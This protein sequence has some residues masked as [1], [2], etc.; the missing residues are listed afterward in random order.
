MFSITFSCTSHNNYHQ[1]LPQNHLLSNCFSQSLEGEIVSVPLIL[2]SI[3]KPST[4]LVHLYFSVVPSWEYSKVG[5]WD[6][7]KI[8]VKTLEKLIPDFDEI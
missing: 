5:I 7:S 1:I 2:I 3:S 8:L 4:M 6:C